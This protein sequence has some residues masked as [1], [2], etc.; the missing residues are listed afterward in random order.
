MTVK[1]TD[2][3]SPRVSALEAGQEALVKDISSLASTVKDQGSQLTNAIMNLSASQNTIHQ[4]LSEK[5]GNISKTDWA[6]WMG[7]VTILFIILG[8]L[9]VPVWVSLSY[10]QRLD[11]ITRDRIKTLEDR[12]IQNL[13]DISTIKANK[14]RED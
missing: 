8:A 6:T 2:E 13:S 14:V 12:T 4:S 1:K 7:G 9:L 5:I 3:L 11:E 10:E